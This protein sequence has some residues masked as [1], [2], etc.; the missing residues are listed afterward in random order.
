MKIAN[1]AD[2]S[3][4]PYTTQAGLRALAAKLAAI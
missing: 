4:D 2:F 1:L 3:G